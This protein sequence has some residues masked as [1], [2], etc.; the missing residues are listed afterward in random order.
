MINGFNNGNKSL[1]IRKTN[2]TLYHRIK[3]QIRVL[4]IKR[5]NRVVLKYSRTNFVNL[6]IKCVVE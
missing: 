5:F 3:L 6:H 1:V 4:E 2:T